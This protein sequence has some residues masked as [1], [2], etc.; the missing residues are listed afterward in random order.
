MFIISACKG[1]LLP[2]VGTLTPLTYTAT[3]AAILEAN[4]VKVTT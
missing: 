4:R 1:P 3:Q 2:V